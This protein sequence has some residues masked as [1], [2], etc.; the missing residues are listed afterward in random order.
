MEKLLIAVNDLSQHVKG[1]AGRSKRV[2]RNL[3]MSNDLADIA[4]KGL[5]I[6][7]EVF[8]VSGKTFRQVYKRDLAFLRK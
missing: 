2:E 7:E 3:R 1:D 4:T 5:F 8:P 6:W